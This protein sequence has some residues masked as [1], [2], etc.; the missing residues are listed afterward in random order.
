MWHFYWFLRIHVWNISKLK[1]RKSNTHIVLQYLRQSLKMI[2]LFCLLIFIFTNVSLVKN[3]PW[4]VFWV[5][6]FCTWDDCDAFANFQID[7]K[8]KKN[9]DRWINNDNNKNRK[10]ERELQT[11]IIGNIKNEAWGLSVKLMIQ[12]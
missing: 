9:N 11:L 7:K 6:F 12:N 10:K 2:P 1:S 3:K 8:Y 4:G 5:F